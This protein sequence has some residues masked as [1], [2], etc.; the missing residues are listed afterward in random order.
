[1]VLTGQCASPERALAEFRNESGSPPV[2]V[3]FIGA[4][5]DVRIWVSA[6]LEDPKN[7]EWLGRRITHA[8]TMAM[9]MQPGAG[10]G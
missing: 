2:A 5:G 1:M 9:S 10:S 7:F 8:A 3:C 6:A 4:D